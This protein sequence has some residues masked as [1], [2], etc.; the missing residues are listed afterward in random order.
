MNFINEQTYSKE[1][2]DSAYEQIHYYASLPRHI[3]GS[4]IE[5]S[6]CVPNTLT[7]NGINDPAHS[8]NGTTTVIS[9]RLNIPTLIHSKQFL[10]SNIYFE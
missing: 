2:L 8:V 9:G 10:Q 3:K 1:A 5:I 7:N 4:A 6:T